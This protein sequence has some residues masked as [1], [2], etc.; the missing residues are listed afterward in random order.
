MTFPAAPVDDRETRRRRRTDKVDVMTRRVD[1]ALGAGAMKTYQVLAPPATHF[2]AATCAEVD[3][4]HHLYGWRTVVDPGTDL[5][6]AQVEFIKTE[7]G[8]RFQSYWDE[9][10]LVTFTFEAGQECFTRHRLRRDVDALYL[11]RDGDW[12][13]NP[14]GTSPRRHANADDWVDDFATHQQK[15]SERLERG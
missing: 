14:L 15:L 9:A 2:R 12:R 5:G 3:C 13:G 8:R 1:A 10:G 7:S 11:V 6:A 4:P